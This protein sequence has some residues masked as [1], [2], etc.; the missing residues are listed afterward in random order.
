MATKFQATE[1]RDLDT[2]LEKLPEVEAYIRRTV[3]RVRPFMDLPTGA[4]VLDLGAAQG[5][6]AI[7]YIRAGFAASGVEPWEPAIEVSHQL[8]ART[9]VQFEI[10]HGVGEALPFADASFDFVH[11]N[12]V[13]EHVDD[14][15]AVFREVYRT[16]RPGGGFLFGTGSTMGLRQCEIGRFPLFAW[17]PP[18]AQRAIMAWAVRERPWLVGYT[19]RP[20]IHWFRHRDVKVALSAVGFTRI[21]DRWAMRSRSGELRGVKKLI[22]AAAAA[23]SPF[24]FAADAVFGGLAYLAIK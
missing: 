20:A 3:A 12:S 1:S 16:L 21:V 17:Y 11:A 23:S 2:V 6:S 7:A 24:R 10:L 22:V 19:T 13:M 18:R 15:W 8:M 4:A 9:G 5:A 14:P